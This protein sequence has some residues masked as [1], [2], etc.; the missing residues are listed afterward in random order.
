MKIVKKPISDVKPYWR[1]PRNNDKAIAAVK[2]SIQ[3]YGFNNPILIDSENVIIAGHSR[4]KALL[5]LGYKEIPV[6]VLDLTPDKAKEFR[7]ADNKTSEMATWDMEMLIPELREIVNIDEMEIFFDDIDLEKLLK[8]TST[9]LLPTAEEIATKQEIADNAFTVDS[10]KAQNNYVGITCPDCAHE[11]F[12]DRVELNRQP[13][14]D[15]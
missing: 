4:Y 8:I 2:Q 5:E 12:V 11:F 13:G 9:S 10:E 7:I 15:L 1:N 6:I 3:Q 14:V